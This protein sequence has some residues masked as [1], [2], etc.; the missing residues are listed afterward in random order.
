MLPFYGKPSNLEAFPAT[1]K[2]LR[3]GAATL[4]LRGR[5]EE[6]LT[7]KSESNSIRS[8]QLLRREEKLQINVSGRRYEISLQ[9]LQNFPKSLLSDP[10]K[11]ELYYD[12]ESDELFFDRNRTTFESVFYFYATSGMLVFPTKTFC[13]QL[14]ADELHFFGLYDY[15]SPEEKQ[16][17]LPLPS[18][19]KRDSPRGTCRKKFWELCEIPESSLL[20]R[21]TTLFSLVVI[22]FAVV[23][24]CI[25]TLPSVRNS[26]SRQDVNENVSNTRTNRSL[27]ANRNT[28]QPT[29]NISSHNALK[30]FVLRAEE[31]CM[32]WF[33]V[34]LVARF[35]LSP[36][37]CRFLRRFLTVIDIA[38]ILPFYI[39]LMAS[40]SQIVPILVIKIVHLSKIF[41]VL[42][43]SRYTSIMKV[44]G[45]TARACLF[46]LWTVVSLTLIGTVLFGIIVYY[47]E[48]WD[49]TTE[50][51]SIPDACW[52][53]VVTITTLGYGDMVPNTLGKCKMGRADFKLLIPTLI[54]CR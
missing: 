35:V 29:Y 20:A 9:Q 41:R 8:K 25:E 44:L 51:H 47:C 2:N 32:A 12:T 16:N 42:K 21:I 10:A 30:Y 22:V 43:I 54:P 7:P 23:L 26:D 4:I 15:L 45:R 6:Q 46:D 50:F 5:N 49:K 34:E 33:T 14:V 39:S 27:E 52:W 3:R 40:K 53:A 36:E 1:P 17:I 13:Q 37:K 38:A 18:A 24:L 31:F 48:Q 28:S 19:V 11:R